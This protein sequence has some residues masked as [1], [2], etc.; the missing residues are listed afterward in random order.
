MASQTGLSSLPAEVIAAIC[1]IMIRY[2]SPYAAT[3]EELKQLSLFSRTCKH[4]NQAATPVLYA[5]FFA[6]PSVL[7]SV[8]FLSSLCRRPRLGEFVQQLSFRY[9]SIVSPTLNHQDVYHEAAA[10]LGVVLADWPRQNPYE[11]LIQLIIGHTPN[12]R[13]LSVFTDRFIVS[14][15]SVPPVLDQLAA[16][17]PRR[18]L[19]HR[20]QK[21]AVKHFYVTSLPIEHYAGLLTLAPHLSHLWIEPSSPLSHPWTQPA[22]RLS[23]GSVTRLTLN[24]G[25]LTREH[26][27]AVVHSCGPLDSFQH[28]YSSLSYDQ[29]PSVTPAEMVRILE[30]HSGT[31]R[32]LSLDLA[33]RSRDAPA[34]F[35]ASP[36]CM[37]G[38]QIRSLKAFSCLED[39]TL[40]GSCFLLPPKNDAYYHAYV[41]TQL[42]P[43]SIRK[44][45]IVIALP[46]TVENLVS[47]V[48]SKSQFPHLVEVHMENKLFCPQLLQN[49]FFVWQ[50][51]TALAQMMKM[52]G[53]EFTHECSLLGAA[54][55][56]ERSISPDIPYPTWL[57]PTYGPNLPGAE[58]AAS[59]SDAENAATDPDAEDTA[60]DPDAEDTATDPDEKAATDP[61]EKA[62]TDPDSEDTAT[63]PDAEKAATDPDAEKAATEPDAED[64]ATH[65]DASES[66][67]AQG[68]APGGAD[69]TEKSD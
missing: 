42:L 34:E 46:G 48:L 55:S 20:L 30:R 67:T 66:D 56:P 6:T 29:K 27:E 33:W 26:M 65:P 43:R 21:L 10:R 23:L 5:R 35:Y 36:L 44:F 39:L 62:A 57:L 17:V 7:V 49:V 59:G 1:Q 14:R 63:D 64:T 68:R 13:L 25:W 15:A 47:V 4:V 8:K 54:P 32:D 41:F 51:V 19:F 22:A 38:D 50:D 61:D 37:E 3:D 9:A 11:T 60:T 52:A 69:D 12:V 31:L 58:D 2:R 53:I 16:Q 18:I 40:D 45:R 28:V 24:L